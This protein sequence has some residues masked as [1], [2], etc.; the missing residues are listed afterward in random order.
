MLCAFKAEASE[1]SGQISTDPAA[2]STETVSVE[3]EVKKPIENKSTG[4]G[5]G[6]FLIYL[7][8]NKKPVQTVKKVEN[9]KVARNLEKNDIETKKAIKV[10]GATYYPDG[11]LLKGSGRQIYIVKKGIK[12]LIVSPKALQKYR[13]K[14][15]KV[16]DEEL[17]QYQSRSNLEGEL[18]RE[19]G[20]AK[21]YVILQ[22]KK[23]HILNLAELR[24]HYFGLE[25]FNIKKE[26][27][28]LY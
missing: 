24:A 9:K 22:G 27:I 13:G 20:T 1:I 5:G 3:A 17:R 7:N 18:I 11:A 16:S 12:K 28:E 10:L 26:E 19:K 21:V 14:I 23:K 4:Q 6:S 25:I 8:Q 2:L 15:V